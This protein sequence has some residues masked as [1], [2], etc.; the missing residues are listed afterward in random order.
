MA[1]PVGKDAPFLWEHLHN[2]VNLG[3][4]TM[5]QQQMDRSDKSARVEFI[6]MS[7]DIKWNY[8]TEY[9]GTVRSN[10]CNKEKNK[11]HH[12]SPIQTNQLDGDF[13]A[14]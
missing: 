12:L 2:S 4:V 5:D 3:L 7:W 1:C 13:S 8:F 14:S 11:A 6:V 9:L 10:P